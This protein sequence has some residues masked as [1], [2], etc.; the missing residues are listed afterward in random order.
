[1]IGKIYKRL[2]FELTYGVNDFVHYVERD[3]IVCITSEDAKNLH[4]LCSKSGISCK[5]D[6]INNTCVTF[7]KAM[8]VTKNFN[9]DGYELLIK[10]CHT[11]EV[12]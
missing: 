6:E 12:C 9:S 11:A 3:K 1:M 10:E 2:T 5:V 7:N 4:T 8:V